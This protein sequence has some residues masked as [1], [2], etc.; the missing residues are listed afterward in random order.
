MSSLAFGLFIQIAIGIF[1]LLLN[2]H[3][4]PKGFWRMSDKKFGDLLDYEKD[5]LKGV[6]EETPKGVS[7]EVIYNRIY[8][9][10]RT[11]L[12]VGWGLGLIMTAIFWLII[13][14]SNPAT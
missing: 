14:Y 9:L 10:R 6:T 2:C 11:S 7:D 4:A 8:R 13:V 3:G 5:I 12:G 1:V